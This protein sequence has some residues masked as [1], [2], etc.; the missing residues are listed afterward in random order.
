MFDQVSLPDSQNAGCIPDIAGRELS[1]VSIEE[2]LLA[3]A[4][5]AAGGGYPINFD[6]SRL[7]EVPD[8]GDNYL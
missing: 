8:N 1:N 4:R 7:N 5:G 3:G 6:M 2:L